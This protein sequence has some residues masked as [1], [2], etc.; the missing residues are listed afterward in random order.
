MFYYT[1]GNILVASQET[2]IDR[3]LAEVERGSQRVL[4]CAV[5]ERHWR[6]QREAE[7]VFTERQ[8]A[9]ELRAARFQEPHKLDLPDLSSRKWVFEP[10]IEPIC[11]PVIEPG[12][13]I[14]DP[15]IESVCKPEK[16]IPEP[17]E[18]P[19]MN[20]CVPQDDLLPWQ[21]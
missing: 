2:R 15:V 17:I 20:R 3:L 8:L 1:H 5:A 21:K 19:Q 10:V 16:F 18:F 11:K 9:Q 6:K 4:E 14:I 13:L 7:E 12:R